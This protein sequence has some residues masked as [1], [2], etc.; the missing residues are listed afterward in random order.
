MLKEAS[1]WTQAAY[2]SPTQEAVT[3]FPS[4]CYLPGKSTQNKWMLFSLGEIYS[5]LIYPVTSICS[6]VNEFATVVQ[7]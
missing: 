5:T 7:A 6:H 4:H 2:L 1:I 3:P